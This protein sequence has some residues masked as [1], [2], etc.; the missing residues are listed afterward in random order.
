MQISVIGTGYVGLVTGACFAEFGVNVLCMDNDAKRIARLEKG[1]VP[2]YEPGI[3][4]LVAKGIGQ[5]RLNFTAELTRAVDHGEVIFIAVGTPPKKDGSADLSFVEEV[6]RGIAGKMASYK[7]VVTK[8][9]VPVGTGAFLQQVIAGTQT[10]KVAFDVVS[11]PE[12]LREGSA[13]EDFMRPNRVVIGSDSERAVALMKDLYR[14][15]YLIETPFVVTDVAT[16][17]MIKYA[18]NAFLA[19]KVSFINEIATLCERVGAD[20]Q[21][22]AKG[23][24]L[25]Q[26]IGSK[27]LHAGPGFGGS[28]FP[29]DLAALVQMGEKA[30]Y[31]MQIAGAAAAVN[32]EQRVRM[33]DKIRDALG[34]LE[35]T[36]VGFLGLSFKPNTND[37][38]EAP[39]LSIAQLLMD[40]G[41]T[42]RAY[43]PAALEEGCKLLP[44]ITPCQNAY[45]T[46][47]GA[48]ALVLMTEWNEFRN[49][50]FDQLKSVM[51]RAILIDLRNVYE[52][53]RVTQ[54]GFRH[55]SVGRPTKNP[56]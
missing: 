30:G 25:D 9:T 24:G 54:F 37:L 23:M 16:A 12:F 22:V 52:S 53:S 33:V 26:R 3:T 35:G 6:G 13:I 28:C 34:G 44:R 32:A 38:R 27:F 21:T 50:D 47:R 5:G 56:G 29:K 46:A 20:V 18:S 45:E 10:R 36:T 42:V 15:L 41:V 40:Q 48:D 17:E 1:D 2:F 39:A 11:N 55:V 14:P 4:E 7:V 19:T 31:P 8:S 51:R 49:L 43:D